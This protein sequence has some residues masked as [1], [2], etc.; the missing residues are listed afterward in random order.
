MLLYGGDYYPEQ[1]LYDR[2]RIISDLE[3]IKAANMNTIRIGMFAWSKIEPEE[4]EYNFEW[5][6]WFLNLTQEL[7]LKVILGTPTAARP[8]WLAQKYVETSRVNEDGQRRLSGARHN[9]CMSSPVFKDKV[10]RLLNQYLEVCLKYDNIVSIHINNEFGGDCYC[11]MC[12]EKFQKYLQAKYKTIDKLNFEWWND[13]WSHNY[14][15]FEQIQ[16]PVSYG[17]KTN[18]GLKVNWREF[19]TENHLSYYQF[20]YELIRRKTDLEITT[21]FHT[22][23]FT[24]RTLDYSKFAK[25]VDYVSL[26]LYP[27]WNTKDNYEIAIW[28]KLHLLLTKSLAPEKDFYL[29]ETSPAGTNWQDHTLSKSA[30]LHYASM[31]LNTQIAAKSY[32]YF[33]L[34]QSRG[35]SE[36]LHGSVLDCKSNDNARVY[37]YCKQFGKYV[38]EL[39]FLENAEYKPEIGIYFNPDNISLLSFSEGPRNAGLNIEAFMIKLIKYFNDAKINVGFFSDAKQASKFSK[40]ILPY[41]YHIPV[42]LIELIDSNY[43]KHLIAFPLLGYV[44]ESDLLYECNTPYILNNKFGIEVMECTSIIDNKVAGKYHFESIAEVLEVTHAEIT[45]Q[46]N[47]DILEAAITRNIV[48]KCTYDY[49]AALPKLT[50]LYEILN[51]LFDIDVRNNKLINSTLVDNNGIEYELST[52]FGEDVYI[53]ENPKISFSDG[54]GNNVLNK[55]GTIIYKK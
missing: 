38:Q 55:Y 39:E 45:E 29:M 18:N 22:N 5:L 20:E 31:F 50:S 27:E 15:D 46:F 37:K 23:P 54:F 48:E 7:D 41:A 24:E 4:G 25:Y 8:H 26:D 53:T 35:S 44:N 17:E 21:N 52:N 33:Q 34:K 36:K 14:N 9:H 40:I 3:K 47:D 42:E 1:W 32:L 43:F 16:P 11:Q 19:R 30:K 10:E 6:E 49:I 13:F 51:M 12:Q 28:T 2:D